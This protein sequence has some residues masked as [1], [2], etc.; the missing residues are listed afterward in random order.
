[1]TNTA[2]PEG[3]LL[4]FYGDDFTG[5]TDAMEV[6]AFAGLPTV[7]F[8]KP[9]TAS[10]LERFR[11]HRGIGIAGTAR[12]CSP[13]WMDEQLPD[14]FRS[15]FSL[16]APITQYK[17]CSTFD[18]S[19]TVGSIGRAIDLALPL[20]PEAWSPLV[21][22]APQLQRWQAF[23]NLFAG[24]GPVRHRLDRHPTMSRHPMTPMAEADLARHLAQQTAAPIALV[25]LVDLNRG[26]GN[27][28]LQSAIARGAIVSFD[29]I[30]DASQVEVGRLVWSNRGRGL[31][32]ASSSGLQYALVAWW[33]AAGLLPSAS[34]APLAAAAPVDR[35]LVLSGS[36]S[37]GT[38]DQ[39][40][41]A[42]DAGFAPFRMDALRTAD[43]G[44]RQTEVE[45]VIASAD[46]ALQEGRDVIVYTA[47][48]PDDPEI[49]RL[50]EQ[51]V[52]AGTSMVQAQQSLGEAL[53]RVARS[54]LE[55][56]ALPRVVVA[57]GDTSGQVV[58][59][60]PVD[61]LEAVSPL[62]KGSPICRVYST[63]RR[64]DGMQ[65]VLKGGQVGGAAFFPSAKKGS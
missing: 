58:A 33:R 31:F 53:G 54:L 5:S 65:L 43:P 27:A 56:H 18:S 51:S 37:P 52:A 47:Q 4:A 13:E 55:R 14:V 35:L 24:V 10:A 32:S 49:T 41:H 6:M 39:I 3:L 62:A 15:L 30:D 9:P 45:R 60:L 61:A 26:N 22:G 21:V 57:G 48:S 29:V 11:H 42:I 40:T 23:G 34:D 46:R 8:V 2:L 16:H 59:Q 44:T 38:A 36:C 19:P 25:D 20:A 50:R 17:V 64:F 7:L 12:S 28:A 1:M 63:A